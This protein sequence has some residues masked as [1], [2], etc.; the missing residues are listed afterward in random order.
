MIIQREDNDDDDP[1]MPPV[2]RSTEIEYIN[3]LRKYL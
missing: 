3:S 1:V 2:A